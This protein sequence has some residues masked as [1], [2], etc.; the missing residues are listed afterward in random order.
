MADF[1]QYLKNIFQSAEQSSP[2]QPVIH[3]SLERSEEE[4][5]GFVR[6]KKTLAK[7]RLLDWLN[8]EYVRFLINPKEIDEAIDFLQTPSSK[9]FVIH[10]NKTRYPQQEVIYFF[11]Y[12]KERVLDIPYRTYLSDL[13][14]YN[15]PKWVETVQRHYLKPPSQLR[16]YPAPKQMDQRYGNITIELLLRNDKVHQLKFQ[17]TSYRDHLYQKAEGFKGLMQE[18]LK[19]D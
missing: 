17:A 18:L 1:W 8:G 16:Q 15:R 2:N 11:D 14:T 6:W 13:R 10:F 9:G 19:G 12:L 5:A 7:K 3:E 4:Q